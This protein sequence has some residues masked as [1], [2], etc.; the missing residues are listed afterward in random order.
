VVYDGTSGYQ[1]R[2]SQPA[3]TRM[4]AEVR[5]GGRLRGLDIETGGLLLGQA[6]MPAGASGHPRV[7]ELTDALAMKTS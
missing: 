1:V 7:A 2:I 3:L 5:R 4:R 6:M